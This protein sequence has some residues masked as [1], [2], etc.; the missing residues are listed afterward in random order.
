MVS[1]LIT[2]PESGTRLDASKDNIVRLDTANLETGFFSDANK[3]YYFAPQTLNPNTQNI[4]G[5]QHIS[6]QHLESTKRAPDAQKFEFFK[7]IN[8]AATDGQ[9]RSLSATIL[10]GQLTIN[11]NY[12]ICSITGSDT[13]QPVIMPVAQRGAQD[14]CIRVIVFNAGKVPKP[15]A[16]GAGAG[17]GA[18]NGNGKAKGG[19]GRRKNKRSI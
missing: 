7:G 2:S 12:R 13:H 8:D 15:P 1:T 3:Q 17:A 14:D 18:G 10:A 19:A 11:G 16:A 6:V 4:Q 9:G 5:H